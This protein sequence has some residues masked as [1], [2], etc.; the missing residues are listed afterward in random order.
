[1]NDNIL[2]RIYNRLDG[3]LKFP[4]LRKGGIGIQVG[5]DLGSNNLTP[6]VIKMYTRTGHNRL[7]IAIDPDLLNHEKLNQW[8]RAKNLSIRTVQKGT[9]S[10]QT[11][12]KLIQG[13]RSSY[14]KQ[15]IIPGDPSPSYTNTYLEVTLGTMDNIVTEL[16]IDYS[17]IKHINISNNGAEY[18][19]LLGM[20]ELFKK[21]PDLNL[22]VISGRP[23]QLGQINHQG[24]YEVIIDHLS[25]K[26]FSFKYMNIRDSIWWGIFNK[27]LIKRTWIVNKP[28]FG[29]IMGSRGDR[30]L[31]FYQSY[32]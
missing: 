6:D 23:F 11:T 18:N 12:E 28:T 16:N 4:N 30:K 21:C 32:S 9:N 3:F 25:R 13:T 24:D 14:N 29:V 1:M 27:L 15:E 2:V 8:I 19:T 26:G 22:T 7:I 5:F 20:E 10:H 31:K 17:R